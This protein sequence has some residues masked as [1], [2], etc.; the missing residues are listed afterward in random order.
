M[1]L[2]CASPLSAAD[3]CPPLDPPKIEGEYDRR[4]TEASPTDEQV[5]T[6][7]SYF[8]EVLP[9]LIRESAT[10]EEIRRD[11][12]YSIGHYNAVMT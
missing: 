7:L 4:M 5:A 8:E 6:A 2:V 9:R 12:S 10:V 3:L 11:E 1:P